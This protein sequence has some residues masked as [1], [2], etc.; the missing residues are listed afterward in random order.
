M[1]LGLGISGTYVALSTD[2]HIP[3]QVSP[4]LLVSL[5]AILLTMVGAMV[6]VP[7]SGYMLNRWWGIFLVGVYL[8]SMI[9]NVLLEIKLG[10]K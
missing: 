3:L 7:R 6:V 2:A 8:V 4:T 5:G 10:P 1:L 9:V